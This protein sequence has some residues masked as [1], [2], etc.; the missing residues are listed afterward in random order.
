[1]GIVA[2]MHPEAVSTDEF[3]ELVFAEVEALPSWVREATAGVTFA[4]HDEPERDQRPAGGSLLGLYQGVPATEAGERAPGNPPDEI[5]LF[6][7][8][9][10]R[11]CRTRE[12]LTDQIRLTLRHEIGHALGL[13]EGR[14]HELGVG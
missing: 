6:R 13:S 11:E 10:L 8:P 12:Q 9:I 4:V 3:A 2:G 1:M 5:T 14:L 7:R